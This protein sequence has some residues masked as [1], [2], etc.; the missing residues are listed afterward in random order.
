MTQGRANFARRGFLRESPAQA[1]VWGN[2]AFEYLN[3]PKGLEDKSKPGDCSVALRFYSS[4]VFHCPLNPVES[5]N[6]G[7]A[8]KGRI[9]DTGGS[10]YGFFS[11]SSNDISF[12]ILKLQAKFAVYKS[13]SGNDVGDSMALWGD[14]CN[15]DPDEDSNWAFVKTNHKK[16]NYYTPSSKEEAD[17][18]IEGGNVAHADGSTFRYRYNSSNW[19]RA[20]YSRPKS[21][22]LTVVA[23]ES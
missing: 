4:D 1:Q 2:F 9:T 14:V 11:G 21:G 13:Q 18:M 7:D 8:E 3:A 19:D 6:E 20:T 16:L 23:I 10:N 12:N 22:S 15:R 5:A 17:Q